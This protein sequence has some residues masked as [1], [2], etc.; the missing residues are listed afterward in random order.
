VS[1]IRTGDIKPGTVIERDGNGWLVTEIE[2]PDP[3][4]VVV[5]LICDVGG[6]REVA[7]AGIE[8]HQRLMPTPTEG[9]LAAGILIGGLVAA[10]AVVELATKVVFG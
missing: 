4:A 7:Y 2:L 1:T 3:P 10:S 5:K 9:W 6:E 8:S